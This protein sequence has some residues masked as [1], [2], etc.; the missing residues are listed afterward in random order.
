MS[1]HFP[2]DEGP[3]YLYEYGAVRETPTFCGGGSSYSYWLDRETIVELLR[4]LGFGPIEVAFDNR[5]HQNGP[6]FAILAIR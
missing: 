6:A 1:A 2:T 3:P 4:E 5:D